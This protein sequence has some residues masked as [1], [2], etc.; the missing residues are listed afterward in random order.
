MLGTQLLIG[1]VLFLVGLAFAGNRQNGPGG[2][3]GLLIGVGLVVVGVIM[4]VGAIVSALNK[5]G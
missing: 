1:A 4:A 5:L 3:I 2:C